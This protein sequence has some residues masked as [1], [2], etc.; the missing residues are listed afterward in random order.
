MEN[1]MTGSET[2]FGF[3]AWLTTRDTEATFSALHDAAPAADLVS[4]F[5][6]ANNLTAPRDDWTDR[7]NYPTS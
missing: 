5:C 3:V 4:E 1:E 7:L 6:K 2:L